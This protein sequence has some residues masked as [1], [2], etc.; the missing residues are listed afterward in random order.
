MKILLRTDTY[1]SL[2]VP[3]DEPAAKCTTFQ[4]KRMEMIEFDGNTFKFTPSIKWENL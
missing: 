1:V 3:E 2:A 4:V